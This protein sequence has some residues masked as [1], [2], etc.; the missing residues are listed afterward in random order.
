M[1]FHGKREKGQRF[2]LLKLLNLYTFFS[3]WNELRHNIRLL[4]IFLE[5]HIE[6]A[7]YYIHQ[8]ICVY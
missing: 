2:I 3:T 4:E 1:E 8:V 7:S 5:L 6:T